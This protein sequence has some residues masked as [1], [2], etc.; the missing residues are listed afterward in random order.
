MELVEHVK[1]L[2]PTCE[3]GAYG[4]LEV[5][6]S[7]LQSL[8]IAE[9]AELADTHLERIFDAIKE[10]RIVEDHWVEVWLENREPERRE[11]PG[12]VA[13]ASWL[14]T[15][16]LIE[17]EEWYHHFDKWCDEEFG[18]CYDGALFEYDKEL[19]A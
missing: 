1:E 18:Q 15:W 13:F 4:D 10:D 19:G 6:A 7:C 11:L 17:D 3:E 12:L 8:L 5:V 2:L 14:H 16:D 9:N